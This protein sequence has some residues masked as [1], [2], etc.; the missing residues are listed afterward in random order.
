MNCYTVVLTKKVEKELK[1]LPAHIAIKLFEWI[2]AVAH[3]GLLE[4]RK[5]PGFHDEP[6]QGKRKGQR[7]IRLSKAYRA[8]YT[9]GKNQQMEIVEVI[10]VNKHEY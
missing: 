3:E 2:E 4:V 1:K 10:E 9:M 7:S 6:L 8:I 5:V